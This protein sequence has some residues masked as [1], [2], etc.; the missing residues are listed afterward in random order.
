[1]AGEHR[2]EGPLAAPAVEVI[3][4][5]V[6]DPA[7]LSKKWFD[8]ILAAGLGDGPYVELLGV[9]VAV[10]SIDVFCRGIGVAPHPLPE[11]EPG[12][13]SRHRPEEAVA[14]DAWVPMFPDRRSKGPD[15][16]IL[17]FPHTPNV[18]RAMSLVPDAVRDLMTLSA[19]HYLPPERTADPR[20]GRA[21]GRPQMELV[22]GRVSALNECF[23]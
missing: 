6:T 23:Y 5:V 3:H 14:G 16:D 8:G 1:V 15:A 10:V 2:S 21:L 7:R 9:V 18:I 19:V 20:A 11:P 17:F 4:R 12:G 13:P 22:A